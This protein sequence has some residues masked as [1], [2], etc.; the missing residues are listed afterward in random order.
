M[1]ANPVNLFLL[2]P[3]VDHI[4]SH[5]RA[6]DLFIESLNVTSTFYGEKC[7]SYKE[8]S[9]QNCTHSNDFALM[10]GDIENMNRAHGLYV[11]ETSND[12]P[13]SLRPQRVVN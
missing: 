2:A 8:V 4:C 13:Y 9:E 3:V 7:A 1:F 6:H 12:S 11:L 5:G 10:G